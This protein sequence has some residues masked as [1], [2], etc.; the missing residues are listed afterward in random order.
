MAKA[1]TRCS[2]VFSPRR[3]KERRSVLP[4]TAICSGASPAISASPGPKVARVQAR[5]ASSNCA[6]SI[7]ISTRRT[8]SC[9]GMPPVSAKCRDSQGRLAS[10]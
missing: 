5:N 6:G 8:V 2:G 10:P 3:S 9:E 1:L 7:S 4:S